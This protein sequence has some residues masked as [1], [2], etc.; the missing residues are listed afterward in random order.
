MR[1]A[2]RNDSGTVSDNM[3]QDST[4]VK[5][6]VSAILLFLS[7]LIDFLYSEWMTRCP[8]PCGMPLHPD[9]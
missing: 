4:R 6:I 3:A 1:Y 7:S 8:L 5:R 9:G 2:A